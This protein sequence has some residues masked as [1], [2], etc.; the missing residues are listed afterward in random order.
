MCDR[1]LEKNSKGKK[2][3]KNNQ[4]AFPPKQ[5][6]LPRVG[7]ITK[8]TIDPGVAYVRLDPRTGRRGK[9]AFIL[10]NEQDAANRE[11]AV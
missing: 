11:E 7:S 5:S 1:A 4:A 3:K 6:E 9:L 10:H 8:K 2:M